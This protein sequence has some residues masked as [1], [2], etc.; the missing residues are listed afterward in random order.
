M[1]NPLNAK[2]E[3]S[4]VIRV[5]ATGL[6]EI[7]C[8]V[9]ERTPEFTTVLYKKPRSP[10]KLR[11]TFSNSDI[12][13]LERPEDKDAVL[14]VVGTYTAFESKVKSYH[15][16]SGVISVVFMSGK[17]GSFKSSCASIVG[18][19]SARRPSVDE[20]NDSQGEDLLSDSN[21]AQ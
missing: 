14:Y 3:P 17:T 8:Q 10:L 21:W 13:G 12:V 20:N 2:V 5:T 9:V 7:E 18:E 4:A 6:R 1:T 16:D 11:E 15:V 19:V